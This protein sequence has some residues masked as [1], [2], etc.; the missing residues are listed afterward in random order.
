VFDNKKFFYFA[1]YL[2]IYQY[3]PF[4]VISTAGG[5]SIPIYGGLCTTGGYGEG[6]FFL[7]WIAA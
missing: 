1:G 6:Y 7:T 5:G 2:P 4:M 3:T